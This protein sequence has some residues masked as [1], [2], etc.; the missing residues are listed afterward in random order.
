MGRGVALSS[1]PSPL[2]LGL[3]LGRVGKTLLV[4]VH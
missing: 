3:G 2:L 4:R 1:H